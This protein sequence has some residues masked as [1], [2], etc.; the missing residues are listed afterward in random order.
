MFCEGPSDLRIYA[1]TAVR[2]L[3]TIEFII[4]LNGIPVYQLH[5]SW[6]LRSMHELT[7]LGMGCVEC[8]IIRVKP[9]SQYIVH[10]ASRLEVIIF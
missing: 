3:S 5:N 8:G 9:G 7:S 10:V 6:V 1:S 4:T 2:R